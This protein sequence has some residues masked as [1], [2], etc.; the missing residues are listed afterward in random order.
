MRGHPSFLMPTY[1]RYPVTLVRGEGMRVF[2]AQGQAY[3][4]FA[5]GIAA[6]PIGHSHP[7]WLGAVEAQLRRLVHVSNL[8]FT[9]PQEALAARLVSLAGFGLV[10]LANSGAEANEAALKLVR[11]W[12]RPRGRTEVV[13]LLG[14]FHGRTFATLAATGQ[15]AKHA[16]FAPLPGGFVHVPHNDPEALDGAVGPSTA[17][18][19]LEPVLGEGG[20]VP[21]DP[22]YLALARRLCTERGALLVL[23]E[24]QTGVGRTGAWF[25]FQRLGVEPDVVTLAKAL[26]GGLPIGAVIAREELA[27]GPGEHASTFG[28][29]PVPCAAALAVL[30]VIEREGLLEHCRARGDQLLRGL[31]AAGAEG[32]REVRGAG[33]LVG[34]E[35]VD[36][37][38]RR[39]VLAL[40]SRGFLATEAGPAVV[41]FAPPLTVSA[42]DV[43]AL[44]EAFPAACEE[45]AARAPVPG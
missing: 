16:P 29:G 27:F 30:E 26:G 21:L 44:L 2:D 43:E 13:A 25:A 12:G 4:D 14:S 34:V 41:R 45:A 23:D 35:M 11:R 1:A 18:V 38:A 36:E 15:P 40:L 22:D 9:E 39:V 28:G 8:F 20:V 42:E 5:G 17:A 32:V 19:L 3:L 31:R 37:R 10:F 7:A 24:V 33:L 6:V